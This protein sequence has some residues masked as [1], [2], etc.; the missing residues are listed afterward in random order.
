VTIPP[1]RKQALMGITV[2]EGDLNTETGEISP[3]REIHAIRIQSRLCVSI[4][5][6]ET[7]IF[8]Y[9]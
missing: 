8:T 1:A 7:T 6:R 2:S 9:T 4:R 5:F 3:D